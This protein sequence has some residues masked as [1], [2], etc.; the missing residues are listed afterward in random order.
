MRWGRRTGVTRDAMQYLEWRE[1]QY[2]VRK[3]VDVFGKGSA[4]EP[5]VR[6]ALVYIASED[7]T[8]NLNY[9]GTA[10]REAIA[11]QIAAAAGPSG[12]NDEYM[13]GLAHALEQVARHGVVLRV[14]H[15]FLADTTCRGWPPASLSFRFCADVGRGL[16]ACLA[17][18]GVHEEDLVWLAARVRQINAAAGV[19]DGGRQGSVTDEQNVEAELQ[20]AEKDMHL[21]AAR[22]G[23]MAAPDAAFVGAD[24]ERY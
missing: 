3:R 2:D 6:G 24:S 13:F 9:L 18:M 11:Q 1:K 14:T 23:S 22:E 21:A 5:V 15:A 19:G 7:R 16:G 10:P 4:C 20:E 8:K 12:R 17:Q